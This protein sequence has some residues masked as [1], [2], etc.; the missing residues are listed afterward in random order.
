LHQSQNELTSGN[1]YMSPFPRN[2]V[3]P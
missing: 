3:L 2:D 1:S